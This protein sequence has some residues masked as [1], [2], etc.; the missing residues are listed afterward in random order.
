MKYIVG[1]TASLSKRITESDVQTFARIVGDYNSVHV[2]E[3]KAKNSIFGGRIAHGIL[4]GGLISAVLGTILPGEGTIY[5][6][7]KFLFLKPVYINDTVT[8]TV[9]I[10]DLIN[11][12]KGIIK[13][14]TIVTNEDEEVVIDGYAIVMIR[15]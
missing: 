13:L 12:E 3:T 4:V 1:E 2:D 10:A 5:V 6:E 14:N 11:E 15:K 7:Q 8:A 9:T